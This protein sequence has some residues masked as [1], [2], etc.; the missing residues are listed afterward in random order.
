MKIPKSIIS[1][2]GVVD[3]SDLCCVFVVYSDSVP[4]CQVESGVRIGELNAMK[5]TGLTTGVA[6]MSRR[7]LI[8]G[9]AGAASLILAPRRPRAAGAFEGRKV[10]FTGW[11][12]AY[13]DAEK[14]GYCEPFARKT[15]A[16][17]LQD[18]PTDYAKLRT[19][20]QNGNPT[21]D[22]VDVQDFF[23][24]MA[25]KEGILEKIDT[26]V[27]DISRIDPKFVD[28]Y[29]VGC[30]VFS[31]NVGYS[32]TAFPNR[33]PRTWADYFDLKTFPGPR[34]VR[35]M[36]QP[37]LEVALLGDGVAPSALYPLD[38]DR[39]FRKLD[40]IRA[41]SI[42]WQTNSQSQQQ[43][44]DG[45]AVMGM[46]NNGRAYDVIKKGAKLAISWEQNLQAGDFLVVPKGS[47]NRDVA[48]ALINE[49][50]LPENQAKVANL[51]AYSPT[52]LSSFKFI[53]ADMRPW[54]ST[55]P[56]NNSKGILVNKDYWRENLE[57]L[58]E[59]WNSWKL[60]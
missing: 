28:P 22:V 21:W 20:V 1:S 25:G 46:I 16:T 34:S 30:M 60:G 33:A 49:M 58:T 5:K 57:R 17:V 29:G 39:A 18:G 27:V 8:S 7:R 32:T 37:M 45:S 4:R 9:A 3:S 23:A 48:M 43:L 26:S 52:N 59:R 31:F 50:T 36:V 40:T 35:D 10:V 24:S 41:D 47:K 55:S 38:V 11:G 6:K 2:L 14:V 54:M 19:M 13:Q 42:F 51:M 53:D 44:V 12:G 15:G 56:E